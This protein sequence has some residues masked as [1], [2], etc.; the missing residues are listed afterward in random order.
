M[1]LPATA[2]ESDDGPK[3]TAAELSAWQGLLA[4]AIAESKIFAS[5]EIASEGR[6]PSADDYILGSRITRFR[7]Q[8]RWVPTLF[9]F[10][11]A[12]SLFTMSMYTMFGGP[13][14]A[15]SVE[16]AARFELRRAGS[17]HVMA[18]FSESYRLGRLLNVISDPA[19]NPYDNPNLVF[20]QIINSAVAKIVEVL[21]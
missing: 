21:P 15:T 6:M 19:R 3:L 17:G 11:I 18:D 13:T 9:P 5:V 1:Q 12:L 4:A 8:K 16:F 20:A 14:S 2:E 10:H 7:F